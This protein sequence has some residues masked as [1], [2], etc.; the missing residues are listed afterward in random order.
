MEHF[1]QSQR[2]LRFAMYRYQKH[3]NLIPSKNYQVSVPELGR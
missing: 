2:K 3:D 1:S